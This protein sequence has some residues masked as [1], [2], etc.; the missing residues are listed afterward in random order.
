M[1]NNKTIKTDENQLALIDPTV[2][3]LFVEEEGRS[4]KKQIAYLPS[5]F[6]TASL[7]FKNI[8]KNVF[9]RKA[10]N[11][12]TLTLK[13]TENV[14]FGKYGRL[15]L[16]ILTT[17]AVIAKD[18]NSS[19]CIQYNSLADLLKEMDLPKQRGKDIKEQLDCF[20]TA[21][22]T[23]EQKVK[24]SKAGY[25]FK[26]IYKDGNYPKEDVEVI[27]KTTGNINFMSG[28]KFQEIIDGS[29]DNKYGNFMIILSPEFASFCQ[30]HAVPI[31]YN[32][33]KEISSSIAK[34]LYA[35]LVYRNNKLAEPV[36]IPR[37]KL[38]EQFMP[39]GEE[40]EAK[41][42]IESNNYNKLI[43]YIKDIKENFYPELN[44]SIDSSGSGIT[45]I[46]SPTPV[47]K[48][49][50]RYALITCDI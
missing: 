17:H 12:V 22:F 9:V 18:Q 19:V 44:V 50:L 25:L 21:G 48:N 7:P 31:D 6:T 1:D 43:E 15:L 24:E 35:W 16:S 41:N 47:L 30:A 28:V 3:E 27:T 39:V 11:G 13:A 23:F 26:D 20:T 14:P 40:V 38:V 34:D 10:S 4:K 45:L 42:K 46:K 32:V 49:D 36:F 2:T 8:H 5:F 37:A 33:Y 29:K